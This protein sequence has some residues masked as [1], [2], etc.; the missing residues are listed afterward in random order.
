M[1]SRLYIW[2]IAII[3]LGVMAAVLWLNGEPVPW[4]FATSAGLSVAAVVT[5]QEAFVRW[6]WRWP[7]IRLLAKRPNLSGE[8]IVT[9]RPQ[10]HARKGIVNLGSIA[11]SMT[12]TQTYL[13]LHAEFASD[14]SEGSLI[15]SHIVPNG[16]AR[17]QIAGIYRNVPKLT[18]RPR[19]EIHHGTFL[20]NIEGP[21]NKPTGLCGSYW[22]DRMTRGE[23]EAWPAGKR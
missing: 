6:M 4:R 2:A 17:Y 15:C 18:H 22:T 10:R 20:L 21:P 5:A 7:T 1:M 14:E 3:V 12:I 11:G 13:E 8:W 16:K 19:S 23:F 9:L